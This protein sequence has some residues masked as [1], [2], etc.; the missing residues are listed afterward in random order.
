M[1]WFTSNRKAEPVVT[2]T[3]IDGTIA[4]IGLINNNEYQLYYGFMLVGD[5]TQYKT[6]SFSIDGIWDFALA[7]PGD[8]V[9]FL[10][11]DDRPNFAHGEFIN[12]TMN[13]AGKA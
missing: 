1:G 8:R 7:L 12:H 2:R 9:S 10:V 13:G 11:G 5:E 6:S 4:R 3:R